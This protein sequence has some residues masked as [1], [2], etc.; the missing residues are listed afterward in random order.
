MKTTTVRIILDN[1][2][3]DYVAQCL[4]CYHLMDLNADGT[5]YCHPTGSRGT[6]SSCKLTAALV[7]VR[8][9]KYATTQEARVAKLRQ[10]RESGRK[11]AD[12]KKKKLQVLRQTVPELR[13]SKQTVR[14][15]SSPKQKQRKWVS[16][17]AKASP[18]KWSLL[19]R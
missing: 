8:G 16:A 4:A 17:T 9:R 2:K 7:K 13:L 14:P 6:K 12:K 3:T 10:T 11:M 1:G 19:S 18:T 5:G 15:C